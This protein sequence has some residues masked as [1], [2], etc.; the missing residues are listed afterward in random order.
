MSW[1]RAASVGRRLV[2]SGRILAGRRGAAGAAGSGMGNSTSSF[3]GKSTTTPVNQIQVSDGEDR[4]RR[5]SSHGN[6]F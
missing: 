6:N 1:R 2:A 3:W 5:N 4:G